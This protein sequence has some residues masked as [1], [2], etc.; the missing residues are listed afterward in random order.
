MVSTVAESGECPYPGCEGASTRPCAASRSSAA[1]AGST[2]S[3]PWSQRMGRPCPRSTASS[4]TSRIVSPEVPEAFAVM[5]V[6]GTISRAGRSGAGR[7]GGQA[8]VGDRIGDGLL[9]RGRGPPLGRGAHEA[10]CADL[11]E[12]PVDFEII[13]VGIAKLDGELAARAPAA[14]EDDGHAVLL[15]PG[16][17]AKH[18]VGRPHLEGE[19]IEAAA[20][21]LR[22]AADERH[23][24]MIRVAA[25]EDHAARDHAVR[26]AIAH[27]QA[28]HAGVEAN[29]RVEIA[30]VEH[31]VTDLGELEADCRLCHVVL[32]THPARS[33]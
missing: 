1:S 14:L 3:S 23:A 28:Q 22:R 25:E 20:L 32:P 24:V 8:L 17:R 9:Q 15:E 13:A 26:I 6:A 2:P 19:V 27:E 5:A 12:A 10:A 30:H 11:I 16:P 21:E 18:L 31:D 4:F 7:D 33:E 29:G